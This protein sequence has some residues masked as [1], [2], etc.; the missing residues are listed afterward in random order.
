MSLVLGICG[1]VILLLF[2]IKF[3]SR[4]YLLLRNNQETGPWSLE[5]LVSLELKPHDLVWVEGRSAAWCYPTEIESLKHIFPAQRTDSSE[6]PSGPRSEN[7][8]NN[9]E[10]SALQKLFKSI[11][12][13]MQNVDEVHVTGTGVAQEQ[14]IKYMAQTPQFKNVLATETT[15]NKMSDAVLIEFMTAHFN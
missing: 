8:A 15:S 10:K 11:T 2:K 5:E 7:A 6:A 4:V 1:N 3:M 12:V 13:H 14:F 9:S